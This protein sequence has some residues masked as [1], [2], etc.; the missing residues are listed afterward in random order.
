MKIATFQIEN[1][2]QNIAS[3]KIAGCLI[4]GPESSVVNYRFNLIAKKIVTDLS[5]PFL[6]T[7]ISK[8]RLSEDRGLIADEFFSL[9]FLGGRKLILVKE[10]DANVLEA[11]KS[12]FSEKDFSKKSENFILIQAGDLDKS[13]P[14]RKSCEDNPYFA[15]IACYEDDERT[16]KKFI[17]NELAK[18]QVK[19]SFDTISY[20]FEKFGKN[21]QIIISE[22]EKII[23]Y[24]G[25]KKD[26][27]IDI[28]NKTTAAEAEVS[29]GEFITS[30]ASQNF[31][32]AI[33]QAEKLFKDG[34]EPITLIRFL[35]NYMQK[36]Y[37][38]KCDIESKTLDFETAVKSQRL[39][40]KTEIE[41][42]KNLKLL[43]LN[44]LIKNLKKL[45]ELEIKIKTSSTSSRVL[46]TSFVQDFAKEVYK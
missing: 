25:D 38:A 45:E 7:N 30:F 19:S 20:L 6:V 41:F 10:N 8:E 29:A 11:L 21:R 1:Y 4:F 35:S 36:L 44:F 39:F 3:E 2:I 24:L 26:L 42:R 13:S 46:F 27:T 32:T 34:F 5:D 40:F 17:E 43:S 37:Q 16:I 12:L 15:A 28:I 33:I 14:L 23:L 9:S 18:N 31:N 22:L